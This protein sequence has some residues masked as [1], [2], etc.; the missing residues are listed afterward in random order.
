VAAR[1]RPKPQSGP[2]GGS[3]TAARILEHLEKKLGELLRR[4]GL[5]DRYD[6]IAVTWKSMG[7]DWR[8]L[9]GGSAALRPAEERAVPEVLI[10]Q[11]PGS[12][13]WYATYGLRSI[14]D[15]RAAVKEGDTEAALVAIA[16]AVVLAER[17]GIPN[18]ELVREQAA[19]GRKA[20]ANAVRVAPAGGRAR[21]AKIAVGETHTLIK[22]EGKSLA[23]KHP[24]WTR[25][26]LAAKIAS[27]VRLSIRQVER[28]LQQH[29][30]P[31][32]DT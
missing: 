19:L 31:R 6:P 32:R 12:P 9:V 15:C 16:R 18:P 21:A 5:P 14:K 13:E 11:V 4:A 29:G 8:Y 24:T 26:R 17:A 2:E 7:F 10:T 25:H 30:I 22:N 3:S 27:T 1:H 28:V 23:A 20:K